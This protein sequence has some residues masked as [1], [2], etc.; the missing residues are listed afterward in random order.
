MKLDR[1]TNNLYLICALSALK[2]QNFCSLLSPIFGNNLGRGLPILQNSVRWSKEF[3]YKGCSETLYT[4]SIYARYAIYQSSQVAGYAEH[5][6]T[7]RRVGE[8]FCA[9]ISER[10]IVTLVTVVTVTPCNPYYGVT[11]GSQWDMRRFNTQV[12]KRDS[13][14]SFK[15]P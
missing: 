2:S 4:S 5:F 8:C 3:I 14:A 9:I 13:H 11:G 12:R 6:E 7:S 15:W 10:E 1:G